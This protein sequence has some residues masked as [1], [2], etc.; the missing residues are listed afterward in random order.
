MK[1]LTR[2]AG[3]IA[4]T[5]LLTAGLGGC[6][7][8]SYDDWSNAPKMHTCTADQMTRVQAETKWC[9]DNT[10]Y[11]SAYCYGTAII[12][13]CQQIKTPNLNSATP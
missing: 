10:S 8:Q 3:L 11:L 2:Y 4:G 1:R 9:T 12:R 6:T 13:N 7:G 5:S